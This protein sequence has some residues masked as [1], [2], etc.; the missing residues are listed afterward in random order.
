MA[1]QY[2]QVY[3]FLIGFLGCIATV[4]LFLD[5]Y[6]TGLC[7]QWN[8]LWHASLAP[9]FFYGVFVGPPRTLSRADAEEEVSDILARLPTPTSMRDGEEQCAVCLSEWQ[10]G[11]KVKITLCGHC[12][13]SEC[14]DEWLVRQLCDGKDI[15]CPLCRGVVIGEPRQG[16]H[17]RV[18][19]QILPEAEDIESGTV[20]FGF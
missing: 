11:E 9:I 16:T 13:H 10:A 19:A 17:A 2:V 15:S 20:D 12:F 14:L 3:N 4:K 5:C 6:L 18:A 1:Q 7:G 8:L